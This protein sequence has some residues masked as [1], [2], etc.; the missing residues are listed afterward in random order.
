MTVRNE[1]ART[2]ALGAYAKKKYAAVALSGRMLC[3]SFIFRLNVLIH[4]RYLPTDLRDK[5]TRALRRKLSPKDVSS[6]LPYALSIACYRMFARCM[7]PN[8][9]PMLPYHSLSIDA[10][11]Q[12]A[13]VTLREHKK[14]KHFPAR[15]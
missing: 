14:A 7:L 2:A 10:L 1:K 3:N 8:T 13:K 9:A 4:G 15:K 11:P 5:K 12:A 6:V